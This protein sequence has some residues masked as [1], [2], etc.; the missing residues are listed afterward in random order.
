[1]TVCDDDHDDYEETVDTLIRHTSVFEE[2]AG[3]QESETVQYS[4]W[5]IYVIGSGYAEIR[6]KR[7]SSLE[8]KRV[9]MMMMLCHSCPAWPWKTVARSNACAKMPDVPVEWDKGKRKRRATRIERKRGTGT[10]TM[11]AALEDN[12]V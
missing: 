3:W 6:K 11:P 1:M 10:G 9:V 8:N 12:E 4:R 2:E 5:G 7:G